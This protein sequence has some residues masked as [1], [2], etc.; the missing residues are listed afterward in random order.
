MTNLFLRDVCFDG[1]NRGFIHMAEIVNENQN[2]TKRNLH[3]PVF[4]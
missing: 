4:I 2:E 3:S 1:M